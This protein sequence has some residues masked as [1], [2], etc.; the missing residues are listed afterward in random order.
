MEVSA[1][2]GEREAGGDRAG[3]VAEVHRTVVRETDGMIAIEEDRTVLVHC[4][5]VQIVVVR[6]DMPRHRMFLVTANRSTVGRH[7]RTVDRTEV[8]HMLSKL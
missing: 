1:N 4:T 7:R 2:S 6:L 5:A 3:E 8:R